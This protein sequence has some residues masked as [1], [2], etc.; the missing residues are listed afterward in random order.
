MSFQCSLYGLLRRSRNDDRDNDD[1]HDDL[2]GDSL[3][4]HAPS[5]DPSPL[6]APFHH[7]VLLRLQGI[8]QEVEN[9]KV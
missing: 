4:T 7:K 1:D 5:L 6:P 2:D 3:A 8:P 9:G